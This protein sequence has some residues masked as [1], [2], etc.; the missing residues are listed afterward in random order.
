VGKN[1]PTALVEQVRVSLVE[2]DGA[3]A[4]SIAKREDLAEQGPQSRADG[5]VREA[6]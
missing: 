2:T 4:V 3:D 6:A 1:I 5:S